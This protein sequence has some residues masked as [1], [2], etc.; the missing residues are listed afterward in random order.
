MVKVCFFPFR[1]KKCALNFFNFC[2]SVFL[3]ITSFSSKA[4][5]FL[6]LPLKEGLFF[7]NTG[8]CHPLCLGIIWK[9]TFLP[10][11]PNYGLATG[12]NQLSGGRREAHL[13][14]VLT[15]KA[16]ICT[17]VQCDL[18]YKGKLYYICTINLT[19]KL[20]SWLKTRFF[21]NVN[22]R[23]KATNHFGISCYNRSRKWQRKS[24]F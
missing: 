18:Y 14:S 5:K 4:A 6:R 11:M 19:H 3:A 7:W 2:L 13:T 17:V 15:G 1:I 16:A 9:E 24:I 12:R 10:S 22:L 20:P 21:F 23:G 8:F